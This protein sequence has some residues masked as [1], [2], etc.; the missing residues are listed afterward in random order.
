MSE[1]IVAKRYAIAIFQLAKEQNALD[2]FEQ[3]LEIVRR[4]C[5]TN[6]EFIRFMN[7][8]SVPKEKKK[9]LLNTMFPSVREEIKNL[10]YLLVDRKRQNL[11][12]DIVDMFIEV[13]NEERGIADA[14]VTTTRPLNEDEKVAIAD[15]FAKKVEK[16]T[17][18]I[19]NVIDPEIL[20]GVKIRIGNII[21][22]GS[23]KGKLD[24]IQRYMATK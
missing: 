9:E 8:P 23:L 20:G 12:P 16:K 6:E 21:F 10:L 7:Y 17:L 2:S 4:E 24:K 14:I 22:D 13:S 15:I 19:Q 11:I 18:R 5:I 1:T 3:S